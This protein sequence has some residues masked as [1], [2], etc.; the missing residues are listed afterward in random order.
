MKNKVII[1]GIDALEYDLVENRFSNQ[2]NLD[3]E[4]FEIANE[5]TLKSVSVKRKNV[6]YRAFIAVFSGGIRLIDNIA[7]N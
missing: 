5:K 1:L 3:L 4:Y 6:T 7:L 2:P